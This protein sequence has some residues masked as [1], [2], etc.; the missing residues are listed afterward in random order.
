[1]MTESEGEGWEYD[2]DECK[3]LEEEEEEE[4]EESEEE[5]E[6]A[7]E[8]LPNSSS[9][10]PLPSFASPLRPYMPFANVGAYMPFANVAEA[11]AELVEEQP[12]GRVHAQVEAYW[13]AR[14]EEY[15]AARRALVPPALPPGGASARQVGLYL[16]ERR[17]YEARLQELAVLFSDIDRARRVYGLERAGSWV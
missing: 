17:I 16:V 5:E 12:G 4:A 9:P 15:W 3:Q 14:A 11:A 8:Q 1:M 10:V 2:R 7:G 6:E 13:A